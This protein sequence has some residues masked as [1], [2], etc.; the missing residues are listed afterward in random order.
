MQ[1]HIYLLLGLVAAVLFSMTL[2]NYVAGTTDHTQNGFIRKFFPSYPEKIAG[3]QFDKV[4]DI[5]GITTDHLYFSTYDPDKIL[6]TNKA[7]GEDRIISLHLQATRHLKSNFTTILRYPDLFILGSN[8]PSITCYNVQTNSLQTW[9]IDRAYS[10]GILIAPATA[11]IR[12]FNAG[13]NDEEIRKVN[14]L[15]GL[16]QK[17]KGITDKTEGGGFVT[18]GMLNFD[19]ATNR[20][21]YHHFY[22]NRLVICDTNLN[23]LQHTHTIDTFHTYTAKAATIKSEKGTLF[24]FT[25]PPR[26]LSLY[27]YADNGRLFIYSILKADNESNAMHTDHSVVDV[28]R[29]CPFAYE[30]SFYIPAEAGKKMIRF[31]VFNNLFIAI[32]NNMV[33]LYRFQL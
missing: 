19:T 11:V 8:V 32:Y 9:P 7:L 25:A 10:R 12:G 3:K 24:S 23:V 4:L 17:E 14:L 21:V 31:K 15:S 26:L 2:L 18:D 1:K 13:F 27:S 16:Y 33:A 28:Y 30:G 22:C 6:V 5:A 29:I 20:I